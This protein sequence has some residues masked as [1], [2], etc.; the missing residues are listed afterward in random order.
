MLILFLLLPDGPTST[1]SIAPK[2]M[3]VRAAALRK[4]EDAAQNDN[5]ENDG[6]VR[7]FTED[8]RG[9]GGEQQ[10]QHERIEKQPQELRGRRPMLVP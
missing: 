3:L 10:D 7:G 5:Y 9:A 6:G 1:R 8:R 4:I 2:T